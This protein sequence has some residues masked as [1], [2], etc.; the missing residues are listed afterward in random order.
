ML[1]CTIRPLHVGNLLIGACVRDDSVVCDCDG[2]L[3]F[4]WLNYP[5]FFGDYGDD[6]RGGLYRTNGIGP[7]G[8]NAVAAMLVVTGALTKIE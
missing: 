3:Y 8:A 7:V 4:S 1:G 6:D 5:L 2:Y